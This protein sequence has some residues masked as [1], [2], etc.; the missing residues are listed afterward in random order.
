M[1]T[2]IYYSVLLITAITSLLSAQIPGFNYQAVLRDAEGAPMPETAVTLIVSLTNGSGGNVLYKES[3]DLTTNELGLLNTMVGSG[4]LQSGNFGNIIGIPDLHVK[5]EVQLSGTP[6][7][8]E[9]GSS[10]IGA[11]PYALYGED[12]DADPE[13]EMQSISLE[14][15]SLKISGGSG[16]SLQTIKSPLQKIEGGY[17]LDLEQEGRN[18]RNLAQL[19][20]VEF[21]ETG[22]SLKTSTTNQNITPNGNS[23]TNGT[24]EMD[25]CVGFLKDLISIEKLT[26]ISERTG[27]ALS[28]LNESLAEVKIGP[29]FCSVQFRTEPGEGGFYKEYGVIDYIT[30]QIGEICYQFWNL[31]GETQ[32]RNFISPGKV[33]SEILC[34]GKFA[35]GSLK[36]ET[37]DARSQ[38]TFGGTFPLLMTLD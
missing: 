15:D 31:G 5:L 12:A 37:N 18:G 35:L 28:T 3:H 16:I 9:I 38:A 25:N 34:K 21:T 33:G 6:N 2:K 11:I 26:R 30:T 17:Q 8:V 29:D 10:A 36:P 4:L 7:L 23:V 22:F 19:D 24:N 14:G 13:N 27:I 20:F 32:A 1:K